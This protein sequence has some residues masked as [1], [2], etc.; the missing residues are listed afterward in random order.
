VGTASTYEF[1][2]VLFD[3]PVFLKD[4]G[5][6]ACGASP[7]TANLECSGLCDT[8]TPTTTCSQDS[9]TCLNLTQGANVVHNRV[10]WGRSDV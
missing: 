8:T 3:E 10:F 6:Y 5:V 1:L 7:A 9:F 4:F 2:D